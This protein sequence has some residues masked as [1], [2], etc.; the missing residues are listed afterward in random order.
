M[1]NVKKN[2]IS[3]I[4]G[5]SC[6]TKEE[7]ENLYSALSNCNLEKLHS[8]SFQGST[9]GLDAAKIISKI[10]IR[11]RKI[12]YLNFS[13]MFTGRL[14]QEIPPT[15][16]CLLENFSVGDYHIKEFNISDN[17][18]AQNGVAAIKKFLGSK[19]CLSLKILKVHNCGL[20]PLGGKILAECLENLYNLSKAIGVELKL[21]TFICGRGR[22]ENEGC[23]NLSTFFSKLKHIKCIE[24]IQ[25]GIYT[26]GIISF[27][28]CLENL[29]QVTHLDLSDNTIGLEG[30]ISLSK[31][32]RYLIFLKHLN[33]SSCLLKNEGIDYISRAIFF[34]K[35]PNLQ[36]V[37]ISFNEIG[38]YHG[39]CVSCAVVNCKKL[40][41]FCISGNELGLQYIE[42]INSLFIE[43]G[44]LDVLNEI[45]EDDGDQEKQYED[46][47]GII[48]KFKSM[49][50]VS[51]LQNENY[52][53]NFINNPNEHNLRN[54]TNSKIE[55]Y[56]IDKFNV[57]D[58]S[59]LFYYIF[60]LQIT[61]KDLTLMAVQNV[62]KPFT[63]HGTSTFLMG[64]LS[65]TIT[66]LLKSDLTNWKDTV[67]NLIEN[68]KK[69][70]KHENVLKKMAI[71][72]CRVPAEQMDVLKNF[73]LNS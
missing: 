23:S 59:Q 38:S 20:G 56:M 21:T 29:N 14:K 22:L 73:T 54:I 45:E 70:Q 15:L 63:R 72:K 52:I 17:A 48:E 36:F 35:S 41:N 44:M 43:Y 51:V 32:L 58:F 9:I 69:L 6:V 27:G 33:L 60:K 5:L 25:N 10:F 47:D 62:W 24:I 67:S 50:I 68:C 2:S 65:Y 66:N 16:E 3:L 28:K 18:L 26:P 30:A 34:L 55:G 19:S 8:I 1:I 61:Q 49:G 53:S 7:G 39:Y 4:S 11:T 37:D 13:D 57:K 71:G 64:A 40:Q 42:K 46:L 12:R 31:G